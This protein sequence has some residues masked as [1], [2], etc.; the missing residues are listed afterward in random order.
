MKKI[1]LPKPLFTQNGPRAVL[2]LHAYSGSSND[3]RMLSRYLENENYTVYSPNFSG[4]AT[5]APE[6]IFGKTIN[7]WWQD[8][9]D[10][11]QFLKE[12]GYQKIAVFGL[13]MGGI[14]TMSAL[15]NQIEGIIGGGFFCSPIF[16]VKNKVPENFILYAE[17][18]LKTAGVSDE[19]RAE[20]M[21]KIKDGSYAQLKDIE[22]FSEQTSH[23]LGQVHVPVFMAQAGKDEMI[24]P[25]GI[26]QTA[27][28]LAQ[29]RFTLNWY[30]NSG[31]VL[32]IG[33]DHKQLEQDVTA[34][35]NTL[36]W[37]EEKE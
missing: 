34:F 2:L 24:D 3:V 18:V 37:N 22:S 4:H 35:L 26:Y 12:K 20:R 17:K 29:T 21:V 31:H 10:A 30:P 25:T 16:P 27:Q 15:T 32:T 7:D 19:E 28:A 36:S 11:V 5:F 13:S 14:F 23:E 1:S 8:T 33:P 6:D 9:V